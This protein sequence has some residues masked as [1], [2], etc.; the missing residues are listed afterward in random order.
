MEDVEHKEVYFHLFCQTCKHKKTAM[1]D[2]PCDECLSN[3]TN[4][5][6]HRPVK[7]E[8]KK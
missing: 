2:E 5:Y 8:E 7:W 6:S 3:P 4:L 1:T